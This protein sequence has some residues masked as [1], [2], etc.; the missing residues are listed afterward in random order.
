V[1]R[2]ILFAISTLCLFFH[3]PA[4][5]QV[6]VA[7]C[8]S[9][10]AAPWSHDSPFQWR[11]PSVIRLSNDP[12]PSFAGEYRA[13]PQ[14]PQFATA[15][16]Y[17]EPSWSPLAGD[18][19]QIRWTNGYLLLSMHLLLSATQVEGWMRASSDVLGSMERLPEATVQ[20]RRTDCPGSLAA[21]PP[22]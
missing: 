15:P 22:A 10:Q 5:A 6:Q 20:G 3:A 19:I 16:R 11:P 4:S 1:P 2:Y 18:S 8:Y 9:I 21:I 17:I 14:I 7:G 12:A 13:D